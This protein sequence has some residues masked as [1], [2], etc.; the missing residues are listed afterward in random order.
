[1][2]SRK[3]FF[4]QMRD[5]AGYLHIDEN[6]PVGRKKMMEKKRRKIVRKESLIRQSLCL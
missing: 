1:M 3:D 6:Y 4:S 2:K 5:I